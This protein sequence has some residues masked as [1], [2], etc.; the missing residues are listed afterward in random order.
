MRISDWSSDVCSSDLFLL[1]LAVH[2]L[3]R[4]LVGVHPALRELPAVTP[5]TPRPEDTAI[6]M[7]Q[8]DT[9][10]G[11]VTVRIDRNTYSRFTLPDSDKPTPGRPRSQ[12]RS[13]G[14]E[15]V[16]TVHTRL[17]PKH[18]KKTS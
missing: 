1:Q 4:R 14:N 3:Q 9:D 7:H 18:K 10:V 15:C 12:G 5:D 16:S 8:H 6:G 2:R 17:C 11:P 13:V